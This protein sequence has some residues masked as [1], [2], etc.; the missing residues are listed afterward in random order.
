[1]HKKAYSKI[2]K[3]TKNLNP[4]LFSKPY[5]GVSIKNILILNCFGEQLSTL[6]G[7]Q[8][9][10]YY[11]IFNRKN[12]ILLTASRDKTLRF[13]SLKSYSQIGKI[14]CEGELYGVATLNNLVSAGDGDGTINVWEVLEWEEWKE[15]EIKS[16]RKHSDAIWSLIFQEDGTLIS[17]G[18]DNMVY[19][20]GK[21]SYELLH[22]LQGHTG[23]IMSFIQLSSSLI[24]SCCFS[25]TTSIRI[26]DI[27]AG[28]C[29]C[30]KDSSYTGCGVLLERNKILGCGERE[31][32]VVLYEITANKLGAID[33]RETYKGIYHNTYINGIV[34]IGQILISADS[35]GIIKFVDIETKNIKIQ[36]KFG[37]LIGTIIK[38][39]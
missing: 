21:E 37:G 19:V 3:F 4:N 5:I 10:A 9:G 18:H 22:T 12:S 2:K 13:W 7:H 20:W 28:Q 1:M 23:H 38:L 31:G 34:A 14:N 8:T 17:G 26:W 29:V 16:W 30:N 27:K 33:I 32:G 39:V 6:I 24:V 35:E 15:I 36:K 11:G 25:S